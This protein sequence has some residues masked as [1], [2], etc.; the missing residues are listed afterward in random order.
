MVWARLLQHVIE[1]AGALRGRLR[2]LSHRVNCEGLVSVVVVSLRAGFSAG[3]F[4]LLAP[5][6]LLLGLLGLAS[7]C[8]C[9]VHAPALLVV[10]DDPHRLLAGSETSG[11]VEQLIGVDQRASPKLA[12]EVLAGMP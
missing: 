8:G 10:E 12:Y 3:L 7:L 6:V 5:L 11:D 4:D 2:A 1:H 9:V